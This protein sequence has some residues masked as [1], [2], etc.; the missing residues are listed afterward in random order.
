MLI[1][2]F[3]ND[4]SSVGYDSVITNIIKNFAD[5]IASILTHLIN[6]YFSE[7]IFSEKMIVSIIKLFFKKGDYHEL[8]NYKP[9]MLIYP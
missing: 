5:I 4:T 3:S 2:K 7:C 9:I 6:L 8:S 1:I